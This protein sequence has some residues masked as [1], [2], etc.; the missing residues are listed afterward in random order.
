MRLAL[1]VLS[2]PMREIGSVFPR[3]FS[4][5]RPPS[6]GYPF[7]CDSPYQS[8]SQPASQP[9]SFSLCQWL[10]VG[11]RAPLVV[12][13]GCHILIHLIAAP[14]L[15]LQDYYKQT[16]STNGELP[17][18]GIHTDHPVGRKRIYYVICGAEEFNQLI[19][20]AKLDLVGLRNWLSSCF[21][22]FW[23]MATNS[24]ANIPSLLAAI[25]HRVNCF[26]A[27]AGNWSFYATWDR[28]LLFSVNWLLKGV[29][30]H[31]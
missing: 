27:T 28:I 9:P 24:W 14:W 11:G 1:K 20:K 19:E 21:Q 10:Y 15:I 6:I 26:S 30:V 16:T 31:L 7:N 25:S 12:C 3:L 13:P 4:R 8:T 18:Y 17:F 23:I 5:H 2:P 29:L 22:S